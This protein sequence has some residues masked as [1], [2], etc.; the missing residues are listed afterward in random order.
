MSE[1]KPE[2]DKDALIVELSLKNLAL[3]Q[4]LAYEKEKYV[5]DYTADTKGLNSLKEE[6][7]K[8]IP[9]KQIADWVCDQFRTGKI[10]LPKIV[11]ERG[12]F[13]EVICDPNHEIKLVYGE[14]N[15]YRTR[16]NFKSNGYD[17]T[18]VDFELKLAP[19]SH[20]VYDALYGDFHYG[21][22]KQKPETPT[23]PKLRVRTKKVK[24]VTG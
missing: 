8:R 13:I 6:L 7:E 20:C 21:F 23:K 17:I 19:M 10:P 18:S 5:R 1:H 11:A 12:N 3:E 2:A 16:I 4:A 14:D 22:E 9:K 24:P 15:C